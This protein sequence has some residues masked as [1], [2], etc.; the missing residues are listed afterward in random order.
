MPLDGITAN[1]LAKE[2]SDKLQNSRVEKIF[3]KNIYEIFLRLRSQNESIYLIISANPSA[4][5]IHIT[6]EEI[7]NPYTPLRFCTLL[8]KYLTGSRILSV[9]TDGFERIFTITF[10]TI[11]ELGDKSEKTLIS[12]IMGRYSNIILT[13]ETQVIID[14]ALH[15][16]S[17]TSSVREVLPARKYILPPSQN[18]I[19]PVEALE[20]IQANKFFKNEDT[21]VFNY[22]ID[23]IT[24]FSPAFAK[25]ICYESEIE[26]GINLSMLTKED[27]N[28][29]TNIL[30]AYL[31]MIV[32]NK[33]MPCV[34]YKSA[35]YNEPLD[36]HSYR[37][38]AI[39]F[40]K[41]FETISEAM[42]MFYLFKSK[43]NDFN[44]KRDYL[45][46]IVNK[47]LGTLQNKISNQLTELD[48]C[49]NADQYKKYGDLILSYLHLIANKVDNVIV[50]DYYNDPP[51]DIVIPLNP[52]LSGT[53]NAQAYYKKY[54][55]LQ[56]RNEFLSK[57]MRKESKEVEYLLSI[58]STLDNSEDFE[59]LNGIRDEMSSLKLLSDKT[60][61]TSS[62][63]QKAKIKKPKSDKI[64]QP[65]EPR[66]FITN[67]GFN[68]LVG[69]NNFQNDRL[70]LKTA[71]P[72][73]IWMHIQKQPGTHVILRTNRTNPSE[74]ALLSAAQLT[75]WY[76]KN[77]KSNIMN[78]KVNVD[79]CFAKD[80][81]KPKGSPPGHV[82]YKNF[83]TIFTKT[84]FPQDISSE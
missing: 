41:E 14:S 35:M 43:Q 7:I 19:S 22:I 28:R 16:D 25:E 20:E 65:L 5:R 38:S 83:K 32:N 49:K 29:V 17:L 48:D 54:A 39:Q 66:K 10:Q 52:S 71:S 63:K 61:F 9:Q 6:T 11:N 23:R 31:T 3:Q 81:W 37:F 1:F 4:P 57:A 69:R 46:K 75:A 77:K 50:P 56:S 76:S 34:F 79:Y 58:V 55:K 21:K 51:V 84:E 68:I 70:S 8:R 30:R 72:D 62:N 80:V 60:D 44:Q 59:D 42:D 45:L 12:E 73:D 24:G 18:K 47:K 82:L 2:L 15:V 78:S 27:E 33:Y 74:N 67:E 36:F 13:N 26:P 40:Y 64:H 53:K